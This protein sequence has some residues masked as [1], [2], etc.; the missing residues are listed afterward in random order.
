MIDFSAITRNSRSLGRILRFPL[1]MIPK[2]TIV[3]I[4]QGPLRGKKWVISF[5]LHS[6]WLGSYEIEKQQLMARHI[7]AGDVFYDIGANVGFYTLFAS[8]FVQG[9]GYVYAFEPFPA[10]ADLIDKHIQINHLSNCRLFRLAVS[11]KSDRVRFQEGLSDGM[12]RIDEQGNLEVEAI[13]L[14]TLIEREALRPATI[15]KIDVEGA[16]LSVLKGASRLLQTQRPRIFLATHGEIVHK[17]CEIFLREFGYQIEAFRSV[18]G[19]GE[20]LA[21]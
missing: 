15:L 18:D 6:F 16:E 11:D 1:D 2:G 17:Q 5:S 7:R 19:G 20:L 9:S 8:H 21:T 13:S 4:L 14:D 3:P 12:G 10:N